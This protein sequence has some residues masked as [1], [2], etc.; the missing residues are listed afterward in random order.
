MKAFITVNNKGNVG[1]KLVLFGARHQ[2]IM[3]NFGNPSNIELV[4]VQIDDDY[5]QKVGID[6]DLPTPPHS[7]GKFIG[8]LM[9][10]VKY[11]LRVISVDGKPIGKDVTRHTQNGLAMST[12]THN[13]F[14]PYLY[15]YD[16]E[17]QQVGLQTITVEFIKL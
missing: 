12:Q 11:D 16:Y 13:E 9:D 4:D 5:K 3:T 14:D 10:F 15:Q 2:T 8:L 17:L 1:N 7:W 6:L